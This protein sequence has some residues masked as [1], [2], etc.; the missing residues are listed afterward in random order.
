MAAAGSFTIALM[1]ADNVSRQQLLG[2]WH[3]SAT[4]T[5][6]D[7][8]VQTTRIA[9]TYKADGSFAMEG[10]VSMVYPTNHTAKS[11]APSGGLAAGQEPF[12]RNIAGTGS[13]RLE[14]NHLI[15]SVT[16]SSSIR[17][18]AEHRYEI[19]TITDKSL[20]YRVT[21]GNSQGQVRTV[22]R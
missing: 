22:T 10:V 8:G 7:M 14:K 11:S 19:L 4:N 5:Q 6:P 17:T 20:T 16:N 9:T 18:N 3:L 13:W 21:G 15:S 2:T 1:A 12:T